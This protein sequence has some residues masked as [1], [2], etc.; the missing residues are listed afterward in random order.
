M[1][2]LKICCKKRKLQATQQKVPFLLNFLTFIIENLVK[3]EP[4]FPSLTEMG[5]LWNLLTI[6]TGKFKAYIIIDYYINRGIISGGEA[7]L[8]IFS[9]KCCGL[10]FNS[11]HRLQNPHSV[12]VIGCSRFWT[13]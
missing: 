8:P 6:V 3:E 11:A 7:Q 10:I 4:K 5:P 1:D 12:L 13:P 9:W 2:L